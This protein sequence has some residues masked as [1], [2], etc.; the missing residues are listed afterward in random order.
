[1][2]KQSQRKKK[3]GYEPSVPRC[4]TCANYQKPKYVLISSLPRWSPPLCKSGAFI[5]KEHGCC[6]KWLGHDGAKLEAA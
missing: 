1:M 4:G 6:D 2:S 3:W 5:V